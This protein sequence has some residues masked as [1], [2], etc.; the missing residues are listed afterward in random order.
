[1]TKKADFKRR[2]RAFESGR[3]KCL[4]LQRGTDQEAWICE[5]GSARVKR[6]ESS[7]CLA[8]SFV[9]RLV[10]VDYRRQRVRDV[11]PVAVV[12]VQPRV[13]TAD[14]DESADG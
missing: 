11:S 14:P 4:T 7:I 12:F 1:M 13:M 3:G 6:S 8:E 5:L 9:G 2:V 10:E